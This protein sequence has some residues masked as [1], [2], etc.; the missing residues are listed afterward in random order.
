MVIKVTCLYHM[1]IYSSTLLNVEANDKKTIE[2]FFLVRNGDIYLRE[3]I[4]NTDGM[5]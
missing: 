2:D 1:W 4:Q 3:N 5:I